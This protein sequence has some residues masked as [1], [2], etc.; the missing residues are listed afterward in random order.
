MHLVFS[1]KNR[2]ALIDRKWK[3]GLEKYI[4]GIVQN[5]KHKLLAISAMKDHIHILI[6]YNVNELIPDLVEDIKTSTNKFINENKLSPFKFEWQKGYGVFL[7]LN[8]K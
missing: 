7:I 3:D 2:E 5:K 6:G 8:L 1:P 4:T